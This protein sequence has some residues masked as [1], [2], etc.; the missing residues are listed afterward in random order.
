MEAGTPLRIRSRDGGKAFSL[1]TP[2]IEILH[3]EVG[4]ALLIQA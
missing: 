1:V 3:N 2:E 4:N